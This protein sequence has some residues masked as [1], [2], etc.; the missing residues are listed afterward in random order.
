MDRLVAHALARSVVDL[1]PAFLD[2]A[3]Y[4]DQPA[5]LLE[6]AAHQAPASKIQP[7]ALT[8]RQQ[9]AMTAIQS[10]RAAASGPSGN[11]LISPA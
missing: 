10:I 4:H 2:D 8:R 5:A 11:W 6:L 9:P 1:S 3:E 7:L